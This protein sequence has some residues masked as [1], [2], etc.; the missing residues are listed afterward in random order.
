MGS[1]IWRC[2]VLL[3]NSKVTLRL[4]VGILLTLLGQFL[5]EMPWGISLVKAC[6]KLVKLF[7][8]SHRG[9]PRYYFGNRRKIR[10]AT[11]QLWIHAQSHLLMAGWLLLRRIKESERL[12]LLR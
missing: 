9:K 3:P 12:R 2:D 6:S 1:L 8:N 11:C 4:A 7:D 10:F 5:K